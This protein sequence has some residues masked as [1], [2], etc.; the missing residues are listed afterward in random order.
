MVAGF[1]G[2]GGDVG[3]S[4]H[5][6]ERG[7]CG[8]GPATERAPL[9]R[10][11]RE[12]H[13][14]DG[15]GA[16]QFRR[17][18]EPRGTHHELWVC[19]STR[20]RDHGLRVPRPPWRSRA[21]DA[22]NPSQ[23]RVQLRGDRFG[24]RDR[25]SVGRRIVDRSPG[26]AWTPAIGVAAATGRRPS[27]RCASCPTTAGASPARYRPAGPGA[28]PASRFLRDRDDGDESAIAGSRAGGPRVA[29]A[30]AE[31]QAAAVPSCSHRDD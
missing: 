31:A 20:R 12:S 19:R 23:G 5:R 8:G 25:R 4:C 2:L 22:S 13:P 21:A 17:S 27:E 14:C 16:R 11:N 10:P 15:E 7:H 1:L 29:K 9:V 24:R 30:C 6:G 18:R 28:V 26:Q 3:A